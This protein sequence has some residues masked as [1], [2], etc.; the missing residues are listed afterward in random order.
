MVEFRAEAARRM[1]RPTSRAAVFVIAMVWVV[2]LALVIWWLLPRST[3][4]G[5]TG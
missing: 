1:Q 3:I 2:A 4:G 5:A